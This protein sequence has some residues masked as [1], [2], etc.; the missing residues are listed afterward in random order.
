MRENGNESKNQRTVLQLLRAGLG[1]KDFKKLYNRSHNSSNNPS[2]TQCFVDLSKIT[3]AVTGAEAKEKETEVKEGNLDGVVLKPDIE[4]PVE[5]I[6]IEGG[7]LD[8]AVSKP[9]GDVISDG[10]SFLGFMKN[11]FS[12]ITEKNNIKDTATVILNVDKPN[13]FTINRA[14]W[15]GINLTFTKEGNRTTA[16]D[17]E[18][19][20]DEVLRY[21]TNGWSIEHSEQKDSNRTD[22]QING[23]T[24]DVLNA[25]VESGPCPPGHRPHSPGRDGGQS[26]PSPFFH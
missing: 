20:N 2:S 19:L 5:E 12:E 10:V 13:Q 23:R 22:Q 3:Y 4:E 16:K 9:V 7:N 26:G 25:I 24:S 21:L 18:G 11:V 1:P 8:G 15:T 17:S 6:K 14:G